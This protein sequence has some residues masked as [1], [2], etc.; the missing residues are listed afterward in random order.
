LLE[1]RPVLRAQAVR[2]EAEARGV[3]CAHTNIVHV[4]PNRK[5]G[6]RGKLVGI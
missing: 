6:E 1:G 5:K 3:M 2:V 4:K